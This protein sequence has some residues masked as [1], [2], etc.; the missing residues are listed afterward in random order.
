MASW[1][2]LQSKPRKEF[3][4]F[5][6]VLARRI[7]CYFPR[8][9]VVP[10]NPRSAKV[11]AYF[12]GYMF[13]HVDLQATGLSALQWLPF[14]RG[15]VAFE[16]EPAPVPDGL[17]PALREKLAQIEANGGLQMDG[18]KPGEAIRVLDGPFRGYEG[19]FDARMDEEGRVRILL[20]L[21]RDQQLRLTISVAQIA[22]VKRRN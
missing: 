8:V 18:L 9:R 19:V 2:A 20:N 1:Y 22:P 17:V 21:L 4:L 10:V 12:P 7:E 13:V 5:D 3:S 15:L 6:Q 14:A 16:G 11:R